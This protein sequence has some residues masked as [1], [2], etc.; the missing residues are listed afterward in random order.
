MAD[1]FDT[2]TVPLYEPGSIVAGSYIAWRKRLELEAATYSVKYRLTPTAGGT[3]VEVSGSTTDDSVWL[4][5]AL[6]AVTGAWATGEYRWDI[7]VTRTSDSE[8]AEIATGTLTVYAS[9]DDRRTH[10]EVMVAKIES[11]LTGRADDDVDN[12]SI[13][14]RS[15]TKIPV[16]ELTKW[17]DYYRAEVARTGG[18]TTSAATPKNNTVRVRW[19]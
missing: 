13:K 11:L 2:S 19:L 18:S 9:T 1:P 5:E 6:S 3:M 7:L 8:I 15:L 16:E 10:A 14:N 12:Y 4:F 17:R